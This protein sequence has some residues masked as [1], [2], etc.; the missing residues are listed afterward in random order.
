MNLSHLRQKLKRSGSFK[1]SESHLKK[2]QQSYQLLF[3]NTERRFFTAKMMLH[4]E[5]LKLTIKEQMTGQSAELWCLASCGILWDPVGSC[6]SCWVESWH[7][8]SVCSKFQTKFTRVAL[9]WGDSQREW[10]QQAYVCRWFFVASLPSGIN[11]VFFSR[12]DQVKPVSGLSGCTLR[13]M[14]HLGGQSRCRYMGDENRRL[15]TVRRLRSHQTWGRFNK[16]AYKG[17]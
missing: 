10:R 2:L 12:S 6:G 5:W 9:M 8:A 11:S 13:T 14:W 3:K 16:S 15:C 1:R 4:P 7:P 17:R